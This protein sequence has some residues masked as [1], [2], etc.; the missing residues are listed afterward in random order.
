MYMYTYINSLSVKELKYHN[1]KYYDK[2][3]KYEK[4]RKN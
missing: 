2:L 1:I 4:V 3:L